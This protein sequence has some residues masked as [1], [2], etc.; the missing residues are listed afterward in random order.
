LRDTK[1]V[2]LSPQFNLFLLIIPVRRNFRRIG[3]GKR[4]CGRRKR[5]FHRWCG[6]LR[7]FYHV[8][9]PSDDCTEH[10]HTQNRPGDRHC[11]PLPINR[12]FASAVGLKLKPFL[13]RGFAFLWSQTCRRLSPLKLRESCWFGIFDR[14]SRLANLLSEEWRSLSLAGYASVRLPIGFEPDI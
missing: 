14:R 7:L 4:R 3:H 12:A 5:H 8:R 1:S 6:L 11:C 13:G 2:G 10:R 9:G